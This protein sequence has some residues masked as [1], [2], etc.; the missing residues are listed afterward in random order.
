[1]SPDDPRH[2]TYA[3]ALAHNRAK[4]P[5][6]LPCRI[7]QR[8]YV[9]AAK[10][11]L[12]NGVRNRVPLGQRAYDILTTVGCTPVAAQTGLWRNNLYRAVKNGPDGHV[13]RSTRDAILR[14]EGPTP[15]GILR[16][17]QALA[18]IG[19]TFEVVAAAAGVHAERL[20]RMTRDP[21]PPTTRLR[22][23]LVAGIVAAY[24]LLH[25]TPAEDDRYTARRRSQ[26][27]ARG[28]LPPEVWDDIDDPAE[29]PMAEGDPDWLD[30]VLLERILDGDYDLLARVPA[31]DD[32]RTELC[33][34][35]WESGRSLNQLEKLGGFRVCA[36]FRATDQAVSA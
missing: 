34:R 3:G 4:D 30:P 16:R 29:D 22:P 6:C 31:S 2:G 5:H 27:A 36:Y 7:V 9:K 33:R 23:R 12:E 28:W 1:V 25:A 19:H 17:I 21:E 35:W 26:A 8:R 20:A 14:S 15:V 11:R 13:L 24:D 18:A 32:A 10:M